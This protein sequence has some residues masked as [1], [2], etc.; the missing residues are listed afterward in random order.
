MIY[1]HERNYRAMLLHSDNET[2]IFAAIYLSKICNT[3]E[4]D[5]RETF[6]KI[7]GTFW[8]LLH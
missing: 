3:M 2:K 8:R 5:C 4:K 6:K 7:T 1:H